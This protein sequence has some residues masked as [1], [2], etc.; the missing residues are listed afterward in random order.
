MKQLRW[1]WVFVIVQSDSM[2]EKQK[3][4]LSLYYADPNTDPSRIRET[5][6]NLGLD[7]VQMLLLMEGVFDEI[8]YKYCIKEEKIEILPSEDRKVEYEN[9]VDCSIEELKNAKVFAITDRNRINYQ[10]LD[11]KEIDSYKKILPHAKDHL[12]FLNVLMSNV[13]ATSKLSERQSLICYRLFN[14]KNGKDFIGC[15]LFIAVSLLVEYRSGGCE[16]AN[17]VIDSLNKDYS[18]MK[19]IYSNASTFLQ[20]LKDLEQEMKYT[21]YSNFFVNQSEMFIDWVENH[22]NIIGENNIL[23]FIFFRNETLKNYTL[24]LMWHIIKISQILMG[25]SRVKIQWEYDFDLTKISEPRDF[26]HLDILIQELEEQKESSSFEVN[27]WIERY[28]KRLYDFG[29]ELKNFK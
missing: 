17:R 3:I 24:H 29:K 9:L 27:V 26:Y 23:E 4:I 28:I 10:E 8:E 19:R 16:K 2:R 18:L 6:Y 22:Q 25:Q 20:N 1:R 15:L 21:Y 12:Y 13:N 11:Y 7:M 5:E 14:N